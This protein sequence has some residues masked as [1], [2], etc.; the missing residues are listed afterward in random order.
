MTWLYGAG[1]L[2]F[3][4]SGL[5]VAATLLLVGAVGVWAAG[6]PLSIVAQRMAFGL[7]S[8]TLIAIPLFLLMGNLMNAT[9][10]TTRVFAV[11]AV[12]V[13]H[14]K[15]G[16]AQVNALASVVFSGMSGSAVADAAGLG[17]IEIRAMRA[18]GYSPS[19]AA[20]ITAAS[21]TV[22]P[23]I[24]PSIAA[25]LYAFIADVSVGRMF[26]GGIVP[27]L[28][29]AVALMLTV[30]LRAHRTGVPAL[31]RASGPERLSA[32]VA[33]LPALAAPFLLIGGMRSGVFTPTEVA[34]V[35]VLYA[36]LL[37][38]LY[39]RE[40]RRSD[41]WLAFRNTALTSGAVL[42][43]VA[44]AH[45]FAWI[46]AREQIPQTITREVVALGLG[47][48]A[49][50]VVINLMLLVLGM[51]LDTTGILILVTPVVVP[52][53]VHLGIDP[54]HF[55]IVMIVNMMIGLITPPLGMALF[56]VAEIARVP[57]AQVARECLPYI[58]A[59]TA[60]LVLITLFPGLVLTLPDL[61][62]G[63]PA[64]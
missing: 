30:R 59:L 35:G 15:A 37:G 20:A 12:F 24:P 53:V 63:T 22:G 11:A 40:T 28:L 51:V 56:V 61:V 57:V 27:G 5:P 14:W 41:I 64:R 21:A 43:I 52:A 2:G 18:A 38:V 34:A 50:L 48:L 3:L 8:F 42:I 7:D 19:Y 16:L 26:L 33:A 6:V 4:M 55:G 54:V 25:V 45:V 49:L 46:L 44:A 36:L 60:V 47:P 13:G 31:P 29:M 17:T 62:Y 10:V 39:R 9:G 32:V 23:V 58:L 1:L